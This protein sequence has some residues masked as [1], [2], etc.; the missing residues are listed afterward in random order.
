MSTQETYL[1][2]IANAIRAKTGATAAIQASQFAAEIAKIQSA[3]KL[4]ELSAYPSKTKQIIAPGTGYDGLS[5]VT[6]YPYNETTEKLV[7]ATTAG[8]QLSFE[9]TK[10]S[11]QFFSIFGMAPFAS[12]PTDASKAVV[13]FF[14]FFSES[15][16][17]SQVPT[18]SPYGFFVKRTG[19]TF[20]LETLTA[21]KWTI[22]HTGGNGIAIV[23]NNSALFAPSISNWDIIVSYK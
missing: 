15:T 19:G 20:A 3:P 8:S 1:T 14:L 4:Q 18:P 11:S 6:V 7:G 17:W 2:A 13:A 23:P 22:G 10:P 5:K 12:Q 9:T 21:L 16:D